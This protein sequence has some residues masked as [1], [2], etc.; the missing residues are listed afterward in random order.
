MNFF[1]NTVYYGKKYVAI[2]LEKD[3][4]LISLNNF[5]IFG[6]ANFSAQK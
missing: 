3:Y 5:F 1:Q 4:I 6:K 2:Y